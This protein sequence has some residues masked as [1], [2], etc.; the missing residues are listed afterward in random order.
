MDRVI[1]ATNH[2]GKPS[3]EP[4]LAGSSSPPARSSWQFPS[5][6]DH[7]DQALY[8]PAE[9][10]CSNPNEDSNSNLNPS[11]SPKIR[12]RYPDI[13]QAITNAS[14]AVFACEPI[15]IGHRRTPSEFYE[16]IDS[17]TTV[18]TRT[19]SGYESIESITTDDTEHTR[20]TG[21][22][23]SG[24]ATNDRKLNCEEIPIEKLHGFVLTTDRPQG[25]YL[26]NKDE[27]CILQTS[28]STTD[29]RGQQQQM[30]PSLMS[31][32]SNS[33]ISSSTEDNDFLVEVNPKK[34]LLDRLMNYFFVSFSSCRSPILSSRIT[35]CGTSNDSSPSHGRTTSM[36]SSG[37]SQIAGNGDILKRKR[38]DDSEDEGCG[39]NDDEQRKR[40]RTVGSS[41]RSRRLA[42]PFFKKDPIR[43][44]TKQSCC[45][46]GWETVHRLKEHLDRN[47]ALPISCRRCYAAFKTEEE[48]D[49]HIRSS[50]QC[51]VRQQPSPIEGFNAS[52][53]V[54][55]KSRPR[56]LK[57]MSEPQKWRRIYLILFPETA[58]SDIPSPYYEFQT[59]SDPGHPLDLMTEYEAYLQRELPPRV[60]EQLEIR[61]EQALNPV[62]EALRVQ[63]VEVVRDMQLEL[64]RSF[65]SS[66]GQLDDPSTHGT[67]RVETEGGMRE[68][69]F[70]GP[71]QGPSADNDAFQSS[72]LEQSFE[73][74]LAAWRPEPY[75]NWDF[76][77]FDGQLFD[78]GH[79]T[80]SREDDSTYGTGSNTSTLPGK[81][82]DTTEDT[83]DT[84]KD[85][86]F[87]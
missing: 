80:F 83:D 41:P 25:D 85:S 79:V 66:I 60:R 30:S 55:L 61:I 67:E 2:I 39:P 13:E 10:L 16:S 74:Q 42:C 5:P 68:Q 56:G 28:F 64:F 34:L 76:D 87:F 84:F 77:D 20:M 65:R 3:N 21:N 29:L 35:T 82:G 69:Q 86:G 18:D 81:P 9:S 17:T 1:M 6:Q 63:I 46:P 47:H 7:V 40:P 19:T 33:E 11:P 27:P 50:E 36:S 54:E 70:D 72:Q 31:P 24:I 62:E 14:W 51:E 43:F 38:A 57:H 45:G 52:Q 23:N 53:R 32:Q 44:Q 8:P 15:F 75:L 48:L 12:P 71:S 73:D 4:S 22:S 78:F 58:E 49:S 59:L 26:R 37:S